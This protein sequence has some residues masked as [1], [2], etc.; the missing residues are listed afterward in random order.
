SDAVLHQVDAMTLAGSVL[1]ESVE[2][3]AAPRADVERGHTI[4]LDAGVSKGVQQGPFDA[5]HVGDVTGV[6]PAVRRIRD[7]VPL[8]VSGANPLELGV[9][10]AAN[11]SGAR[12]NASTAR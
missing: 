10:H 9:A 12:S 7:R 3:I 6:V 11:T 8:P 2:E 4:E 5:L 1:T